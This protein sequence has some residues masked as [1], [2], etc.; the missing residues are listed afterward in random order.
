M[1]IK[2]L[3]FELSNIVLLFDDLHN[4]KISRD[5]LFSVFSDSSAQPIDIGPLILIRYP[6]QNIEITVI[7]DDGRAEI[8]KMHPSET[9]WALLPE[10]SSKVYAAF[11]G[12]NL[13]SY[14]FNYFAHIS[15][16]D[17]LDADTFLVNQFKPSLENIEKQTGSNITNI[18]TTLKYEG[19]NG[20]NQIAFLA[21]KPNNSLRITLNIHFD[22]SEL[23]DLASLQECYIEEKES[24]VKLLANLFE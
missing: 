2:T 11:S 15:F 22:S 4:A 9:D 20:I 16:E 18:S 8:K 5:Q 6:E 24:F 10:I 17:T 19:K 21:I 7:K 1:D 14:G 13:I 12:C 23:K 3:S